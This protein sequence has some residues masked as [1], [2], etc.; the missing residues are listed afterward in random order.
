MCGCRMNRRSVN[1]GGDGRRLGRRPGRRGRNVFAL[2]I[3][4]EERP[5]AR[6][7]GQ[8]IAVA[9]NLLELD[10]RVDGRGKCVSCV[11]LQRTTESIQARSP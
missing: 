2:V 1:G 11:E 5:Q 6:G 10:L 8:V 9:Q 7:R 4:R 3:S